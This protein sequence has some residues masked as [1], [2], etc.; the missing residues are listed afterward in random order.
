VTR[1]DADAIFLFLRTGV[2]AVRQE[3]RAHD[4]RFPYDSQLALAAWRGLFFRPARFEPD[5]GRPVEVNRGAYLVQGLGHCS[6]CHAGY[7]RLGASRAPMALGGGLI[8]LLDWYAPPLAAA[9]RDGTADELVALLRD[10]VSTRGSAMGPMAEVVR[11]STQHW[12]ETDLRAAA[13]YLRALPH[14]GPEAAAHAPLPADSE[15]MRRGAGLYERHCAD[16]HGA[17][18]Q[19]VPGVYPPLAG[20]RAVAGQPP[21]NTIRAVLA[22]GFPPSTRGNPRPYGMPPFGAELN[23]ADVAAVVTYVRGSWGNAGSAVEPRHVDRF[24]RGASD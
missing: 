22:G 10:G 5:P 18:G 23:D 13:A 12:S 8:P 2:A 3:N 16:C 14:A 1:E 20:N 9:A 11:D 15:P 19:G 4:L 17:A 6:A 7:N 21:A 24:R